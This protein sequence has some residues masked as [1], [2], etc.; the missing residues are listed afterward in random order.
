MAQ[1]E[2]TQTKGKPEIDVAKLEAGLEALIKEQDNG[3]DSLKALVR[4]LRPKLRKAHRRGLAYHKLADWLNAQG[5]KISVSTLKTYLEEGMAK[6]PKATASAAKLEV[7][8]KA[9]GVAQ[10]GQTASQPANKGK[11]EEPKAKS[12]AVPPP[13]LPVA[14]ARAPELAKPAN[15]PNLY[16]FNRK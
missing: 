3:G 4:Q 12:Q 14:P 15:Q 2:S 16:G 13:L 7:E 11:A 6:K 8:A 9:D 5:V 10:D 1:T